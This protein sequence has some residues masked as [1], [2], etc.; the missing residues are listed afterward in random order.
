[1]SAACPDCGA[2]VQTVLCGGK[3][4]VMCQAEKH[5]RR[6]DNGALTP[7]GKILTD[8]H[9]APGQANEEWAR[10]NQLI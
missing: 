5:R 2:Q 1:M 4:F 6:E 10:K 9:D 3:H 7:Y 8:G